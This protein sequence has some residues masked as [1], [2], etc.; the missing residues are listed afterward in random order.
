MKN[1]IKIIHKYKNNNRRIQ[2]KI[3]IFVGPSVDENIMKILNSIKNKDF[4]STL[5]YLSNKQIK[6]ITEYYGEK[7]YE[8]FFTSYHINNMLSLLSTNKEKKKELD[9]KLGK[10]FI[11]K[12]ISKPIVKNVSYNY[13]SVY[14]LNLSQS[15]KQK[16][17]SKKKELDFRTY[18]LD[19]RVADT[20]QLDD[21]LELN[22]QDSNSMLGGGED[23]QSDDD[24]Q[25]SNNINDDDDDDISVSSNIDVDESTN[26]EETITNE[27]LDDV[28]E[29]D[30]NLDE[31]N[32]IYNTVDVESEKVAK[33]TL[34]LINDTVYDKKTEKELSKNEINYDN[35]YDM[36]PYDTKIEEVYNK[37]Y[38]TSQYIFMDDT[39]KVM[40]T[41]IC[42]SIVVNPKYGDSMKLLPETQYFWSSYIFEGNV[43]NVMIGQ[44]W[45]R[46]N[47]LLKIDIIPNEN[48][49]VYEKLRNNLCYLK[50]SFGYKI[51]RDDDDTN[52]INEYSD[53]M[54]NNEIMMLDIYN[55][56]GQNY[57]PNA[58]EI[59]NIYDVYVNIYFP[60]INYERIEQILQMLN[61]KDNKELSYVA[62]MFNTVN[63]DLQL[64][65]EIYKN[66]ESAKTKADK[67]DKY[68]YKNHIIQSII[69]VNIMDP[70]N[71]TGT[72]SPY[73]FNL[74][75][76][77]DNFI[78]NET[79]PFIQIQ[80]HDSIP[81]YKFFRPTSKFYN[82]TNDEEQMTNEI[83]A[84]W[85]ENAPFGISI[86]IKQDD[87]Y[88][89]VT[90]N[91]LGRIEYKITFK[92]NEIATIEDINITYDLIRNILKKI[93]SENKKIK[94]I[95]PSND[96]F[97]FA[98]IN[99]IQ[100]FTL[101]EKHKIN[102]NDLSDFARL[103]F[104]YVSLVIDP[105]KRESV[106]NVTDSL[107][108]KYGTY[109]R[110][111]RISKYDNRGKIH[112]RIL[113]FLKNYDLSDKEIIDEISKQ[114]NIT[115]ETTIKEFDFVK[116]KYSK[117]IK[118]SARLIKQVKN[119]PRSKPPG[120]DISIQGRDRENYKI[121]ITGARDKNQL[122]DIISFMKVLIYI[123]FE[124]YLQKNKE[125][126][127]LKEVLKTLNKIAKRRNKV[128]DIVDHD[129]QS[130]NVKV[131]TNLD[132]KRLGYKPEEGQSQ[133]TRSC[134][135]SGTNNKR[136]P[137]ITNSAQIAKLLK[138]GY[139]LNEKTNTYERVIEVK[140][141]GKMEK[142]VLRAIKL[143]DDN[144]SYNYFT[145]NPEENQD[146]VFIGFLTK[147]NNPDDLCMPCCF[148]KDMAQ[149]VNKN[150]LSYY[151]KCIGEKTE[152]IEKNKIEPQQ[153]D[154]IYILKET[155]KVQDGRF[156]HLPK[157]LDEF[158]N[159]IW[160][161]KYTVKNH[162]LQ[163][164]KTGYFFKYT[165]KHDKY[166]FLAAIANI[167]DKSI[168]EIRN[169]IVKTLENDNKDILFTYLN[170]GD[171]KESF[172]TRE[173]FIDYIKTSNYL[174][175]DIVGELIAL[176]N[177][178]SKKGIYYYILDKK[179]YIIKKALEKDRIEE[180][181]YMTCLNLENDFMKHEDRDIVILI[182]EGKYY[183]P[184]Y[185]VEKDLSKDNSS[186]NSLSKANRLKLQKIYNMNDNTQKI[187]NELKN[188]YLKSCQNK[189]L[190]K[191]TISNELAC[192]NI[193]LDLEKNS[194]KIKMQYVDNRN[195]CK[196]IELQDNIIL[197]VKLSGIH[198]NYPF[199]VENIKSGFELKETINMIEKINKKINKDYVSK[200]VI[201]DSKKNDMLHIVSLLLYNS[202]IVPVKHTYMK[203]KD[204]KN[205]GL[206]IRFQPLEE[207]I[208]KE[209]LE[210]N[211][212][213]DDRMYRVKNRIF[214]SEGYNLY[215][216]ELSY[217]LE[218]NEKIKDNIITIVRNNT[219]PIKNKK[220]ELRKILYEIV[221]MKLIDKELIK[222]RSSSIAHIVKE[223]PKLD[224]YIVSNV[225]D[226]CAI[227]N[228]KE[229]CNHNLHCKWDNNTCKLQLT[230]N[231][232]IDYV[233]QILEELVQDGINFKE[234]IQENNY[235][236]SDVIDYNIYTYRESQIIIKSSNLT[237]KKI[238]SELFGK[239]KIPSIGKRHLKFNSNNS[240]VEEDYPELI[241][242]GKQL[243]QPIESNNDSIIRAYVNCLYWINNSLYNDD[244]RN[245]GYISE[246]QTSLTHLFKANIIDFIQNN[247]NNPEIKKYFKDSD[248]F[249]ESSINKFRKSSYNT[250][251]TIELYILSLL[252]DSPI[253]VYDNYSNVV[254]IFMNGIVNVTQE[255]IK[256]Y[257]RDNILNKTIFLKFEFDNSEKI[258]RKISSI[259]YR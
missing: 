169:I 182:K 254:S 97:K 74:N 226:Y 93:N 68:F 121:R 135:N 154:K 131:I 175:Y 149:S 116:E 70:K 137:D 39:V 28:V 179:T 148:K 203:E 185:R 89:S 246:L 233:N 221:G 139:V 15:K 241:E 63:I 194:F 167:F 4:I 76:I 101:P 248:N 11:S 256:T 13:A 96:R 152:N 184:I 113:Y 207:D 19:S 170:N 18:N 176:H 192:K 214:K 219:I 223:L 161:N 100:K 215:R 232:C 210:K 29:D 95:L 114:F 38:I 53:F 119:I 126:S 177:I 49:K 196:F 156:I 3:Y 224:N 122:D 150:K 7:W 230:E 190:D 239:D 147:G 16:I 47:E 212:V 216:L 87:R 253:V 166:N 62:N 71:I 17:G 183:F 225:R 118:K 180:K 94:F 102:H 171:I 99:T 115:H 55:E 199:T 36:L 37:Y 231:M 164:S 105:K 151:K 155:N 91:E 45:I 64:E 34:K 109:L 178:I 206:S 201:Y 165:V 98:F 174:E 228:N 186:K 227:N 123:Y 127:H 235:Y 54:T 159:I 88:I 146:Q 1:P 218:H 240:Y 249:F 213:I 205:L 77:F 90:I 237:I 85:F 65:T 48:L 220:H 133:W 60:N 142:V 168:S 57:S 208:N 191:V 244:S 236:V 138:Q 247:K 181:Y 108:S 35:S 132:K 163:E 104:P 22:T 157:H 202:L 14:Y 140:K 173:K 255:T 10:E 61:G 72:T 9:N 112:L 209:I 8:F 5:L 162:Y 83:Y 58:E 24:D 92:E 120:I 78:V 245:L 6:E 204:I 242:L 117:I 143:A 67:F 110:Y 30:F 51:K 20:F 66:I 103:F 44:K 75:R 222:S 41:K 250:D 153:T 59:K 189:L 141:K 229:K 134:Q 31:L 124:T 73:K 130:N 160:K 200:S 136:R 217:F 27:E 2:Y 211:V 52:I 56:F 198:Y 197:P 172:K 42:S 251:G 79:Y 125:Y 238:M 25:E 46:R 26:K 69:H 86:K 81:T 84:K 80:S 43:E 111:K 158:F 23:L 258:P 21:E 82:I 107:T 243:I 129:S 40:R 188:Y 32:K 12:L 187:I 193:I 195:K 33:D 106:K 259:Y 128:V 257:T 50:D 144:N 252:I 234:I 145:C